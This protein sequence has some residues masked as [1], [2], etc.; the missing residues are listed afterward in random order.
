MANLPRLTPPYCVVCSRPGVNQRCKWCKAM[1][2]V[3]DGIRAP[4]LYGKD[5]LIQKALND[6][7]FR[8]VRTMAPELARHL[9]DYLAAHS[10]P[11]DVIVPVPSHPRR[12]RSRGFNQAALL[13]RELGKLIDMPVD[14][15]LLVKVKNTPS[16][17]RMSSPGE[18]WRNVEGSFGCDGDVGGKAVLLVDD[19]ATTG[20]TMSACAG[21][22]K[23]AGASVVWGLAVAR[24]P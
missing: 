17:L 24:T 6:F 3:V 22:L 8:S 19:I 15:K 21:A 5:S 1:P 14:E 11:G 18:R 4:F 2:V 23:D 13:G 10:V 9:A 20:G 12:L 16:Q 7:K